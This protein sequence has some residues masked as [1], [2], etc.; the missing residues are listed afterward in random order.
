MAYSHEHGTAFGRAIIAGGI[1]G[2]CDGSCGAG[3]K[4][5]GHFRPNS[6]LPATP[7]SQEE[8]SRGRIYW[9]C[10]VGAEHRFS[11]M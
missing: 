9:R 3:E 2:D 6:T 10:W 7:R 1:K 8:Q 4:Q 5:S 11:P